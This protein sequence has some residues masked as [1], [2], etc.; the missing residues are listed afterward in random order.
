M[1]S[2]P[3]PTAAR[4]VL[5]SIVVPMFNEAEGIDEFFGVVLEVARG[6]TEDFEFVCVNDGSG[7][8]TWRRLV[9]WRAREPRIKIIDLARNFGKEAAITAGLWHSSGAAVIPI[10]ADLQ[11][12]PQLIPVLM[13]KW[14]EGYDVV[15]A[16]RGDRQSDHPVKRVT[17]VLFYDLMR[18]I[19]DVEL[20]AQTGDFR[21]MDR[22]VVEAFKLLP[23][24][25]RF[26][27]GIFAW[28][29]FRQ[30]FVTYS[31]PPRAAGKSKWTP[32][33]L[34]NFALDGI[35]S[36]T[37]M[38]LR[39]WTY[40]G[41]LVALAAVAYIAEV[42]VKTLILGIDMP[43]YASLIVVLLFASG[44][45]MIG[46]GILGEYIG[47]IFHEVKGRPVYLI[48]ETSGLAI[49]IAPS[50]RPEF[51]GAEPGGRTP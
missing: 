15:L 2:P 16:Q 8:D 50:P 6:V 43:G 31:R 10:D 48:R 25:S 29:G 23:E 41:I 45:N 24:R 46:F 17:A 20:P 18:R 44:M 7:D 38:P 1:S 30:T 51:R 19:G 3:S 9:E 27:K 28:L 5:L 34:W 49:E 13:S 42:I 35:V 22:R 14:R 26:L 21:L 39:I 40:M 36:F 47:R 37:T 32:W 4:P 33:K 12:P 11:D